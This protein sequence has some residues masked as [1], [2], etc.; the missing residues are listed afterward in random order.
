MADLDARI[1]PKASGTAS[2]APVS[3]DLFV[4]EI[5]INTADGIAYVKHTDNTIKTLGRD[6]IGELLD[7][8][9]SA[10]SDG[11][12]LKWSAASGEWQ[13]G[14]VVVEDLTNVAIGSLQVN[15]VL[16]WNGTQWQNGFPDISQSTTTNL[17]DVSGSAPSDGEGLQYNSSSGQYEPTAFF[18]NPLT[19]QGDI[20]IQFG[21]QATRLGIGA[22]NQVLVVSASGVPAWSDPVVGGSID[23]LSDVDITTTSP[24]NG[25]LLI[26]SSANQQFEPGVPTFTVQGSL[27]DLDD[28]SSTSPSDGQGLVWNASGSTWEPG[29]VASVIKWSLSS[30]GNVS[31]IFSG[32]GFAG[33]EQ[34]P[35]LYLVRGQ[36]Y[37]IENLMGAHPFQ[38]QSTEGLGGTVYNDGITNNGVSNGV[39]EWEVRMDAP[40]TLYY[41][42][43][44]HASMAGT[45]KVLDATG[46]GGGGSGAGIYLTE[47]QTASGGAADFT[48]LGYS[49]ILQKVSSNLDAWIVLYSSAAERTADASRPY[50]T[51]PTPG[52]GVLFEAYVT[53]GGTVVATPGTTYM[54]ND[55]TLTE[56]VY[57]AVRDQSGAS[58][59]A[60]VT[61][62]AYGLAAITTVSG[63][64]FGSG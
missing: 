8:S 19:T 42:C 43:T 30:N 55:A 63:G 57:A 61:F 16:E 34:N 15:Q 53:A 41:Q 17:S 47:T 25:D 32:P 27:G 54:N 40:S 21:G 56:A 59:A 7:V 6:Y 2:E 18:S 31:Y 51:D 26:W 58:V 24:V 11:N 5:A 10:P 49:G 50:A 9:N 46:S 45:I 44:S 52:S 28:V 39:L 62:T 29:D 33:T 3:G 12:S 38:I 23:Q 1:I 37:K 22:T 48:G 60:Q 4:G 36:S 35:T 13:P 14:S 64:T 20:I